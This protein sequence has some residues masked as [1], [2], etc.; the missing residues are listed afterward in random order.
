MQK[1]GSPGCSGTDPGSGPGSDS[2]DRNGNSDGSCSCH[3]VIILTLLEKK[4]ETL[5]L[6]FSFSRIWYNLGIM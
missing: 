2:P 1:T 6:L 4:A 5:F 3:E